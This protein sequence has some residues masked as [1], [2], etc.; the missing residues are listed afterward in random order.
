LVS[1]AIPFGV[2]VVIFPTL[3]GELYG[4]ANFGSYYGFMLI[5]PTFAALATPNIATAIVTATGA[6]TDCFW[7]VGS[8]SIVSGFALLFKQPTPPDQW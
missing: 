1:I 4:P 6:Y 2:Y 8:L 7:I 5:G 3:I